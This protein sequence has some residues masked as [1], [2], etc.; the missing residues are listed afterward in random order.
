MTTQRVS[1]VETTPAKTVVEVVI[2]DNPDLSLATE[3]VV[4]KV[5]IAP[6]HRDPLLTEIL[7]AALSRARELIV[8]EKQANQSRA[9]RSR[10]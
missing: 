4:L 3:S 1:V 2:A 5:Q 9:N 8:E 7:E 6:P 10:E